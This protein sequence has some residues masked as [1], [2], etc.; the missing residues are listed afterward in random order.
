VAAIDG[1]RA[2]RAAREINQVDEE[3]VNPEQQEAGARDQR[4]LVRGAAEDCGNGH[5]KRASKGG[6][7]MMFESSVGS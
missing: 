2:P 7:A 3:V 4:Q 5:A 1:H 6:A